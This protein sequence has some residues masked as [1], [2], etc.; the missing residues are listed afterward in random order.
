MRLA[1]RALLCALLALLLGAEVR[2]SQPIT[3]LLTSASAP[4]AHKASSPTTTP[5]VSPQP[6][7]HAPAFPS[8]RLLRLPSRRVAR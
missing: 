8:H 2:V 7:A 5:D 3:A 4:S 6:D 1:S